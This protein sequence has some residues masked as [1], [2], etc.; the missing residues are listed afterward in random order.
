MIL[1]FILCVELGVYLFRQANQQVMQVTK[2]VKKVV[3]EC[4]LAEAGFA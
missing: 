2:N 1:S 4:G 3:F